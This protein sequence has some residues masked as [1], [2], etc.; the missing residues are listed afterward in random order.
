MINLGKIIVCAGHD[1]KDPGA[2]AYDGT[3]EASL[4]MELRELVA[5]EIMAQGKTA[6]KTFGSVML[7]NDNHN[8]ITTIR[9]INEYATPRHY[10]ID[11]HFNY[12]APGAS[13]TEAFYSEGTRRT[14]ILW[15]KELSSRVAKTLGLPDRGGKS[16][17]ETAVRRLGILSDTNC[18]FVL[19]E[20]CFL[21]E[22]D[23]PI[24]RDKKYEVAKIIAT[25]LI[26]RYEILNPA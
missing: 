23:L 2:I 13:G 26:E 5:A 12:N 14:N 16:E 17:T 8:L 19:L 20:P 9:Q 1:L 11:L 15:T 22:H 24:Y 3:T 6:T 21:N 18:P 7:D 25:F 4:T 10:G